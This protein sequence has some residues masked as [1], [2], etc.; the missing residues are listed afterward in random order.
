MFELS[1][2][3]VKIRLIK[4]DDAEFV[5]SL[6]LDNK[7]N[8]HLSEV[9]GNVSEQIEWIRNY[10]ADEAQGL[11]YYFIIETLEGIPCGTVRVYDFRTDSFCWGSWIL[12]ERKTKYAALES[13]FLVYKFG[14]QELGFDKSHFDVRKGNTRVIDFHKKFGAVKTAEDSDN[15]YFEISQHSVEKM[16]KKFSKIIG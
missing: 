7:Y 14:F 10:K 13:A 6:R 3:T 16:Q 9:S 8:K 1:S 12:N 11:Q 2:K 15:Y 5:L 4:E